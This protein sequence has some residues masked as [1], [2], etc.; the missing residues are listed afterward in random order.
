MIRI[1]IHSTQMK[2]TEHTNRAATTQSYD[3]SEAPG[4]SH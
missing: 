2:K 4:T 1:P 3:A